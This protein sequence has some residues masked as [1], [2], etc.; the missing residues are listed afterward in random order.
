MA[1]VEG[2][3]Q[4]YAEVDDPK[5]QEAKRQRLEEAV[6]NNPGQ[7]PIP[8]PAEMAALCDKW[9]K[10]EL[11]VTVFTSGGGYLAYTSEVRGTLKMELG[12]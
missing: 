10:D 12:R 3:K 11:V 8:S 1:Q 7:I 2:K 4:R 9:G 5:M 6:L